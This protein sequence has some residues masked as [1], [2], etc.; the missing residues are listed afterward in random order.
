MGQLREGKRRME[1]R[2][3]APDLVVSDNYDACGNQC[4]GEPASNVAQEELFQ[5]KQVGRP[6]NC[7]DSEL[8]TYLQAL[9]AGFLPT[10]YSDTSQSAQSKSMNIASRSYQRGKKTVVFHGFPSLQMSRNLTA[11][12]GAGMSMSSAADSH[13]RTLAPPEKEQES[14]ASAPASGWK[15]RES[16]TRYDPSSRSWRTRQCS[17]LGDLTEF[18]E[19]W[20]RWG[21]MR[22]GECSEQ[23]TLAP[24]TSASGFG[25]WPTP[26]RTDADRGGRG[27]LIQAVRGNSN[28]HFKMWPTPHGFSKDGK[29]N[30][31]SGNELWRAVN[32][33]PFPTPLARDAHNRSG[34]AKRYLEQGRVNLQDRMAADGIRGSLNPTWVEWLMGWPLGWT[35][36]AASAM[37][38]FRVWQ[39]AHGGF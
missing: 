7:S 29:S 35:D 5:E 27:D 13:A 19:T 9:E 32:Q 20:P 8:S 18:S 17:L 38:R 4:V 33:R 10:F 24:P 30:G 11:P 39:Q 14:A 37:D 12:R 31:P 23:T 36:C 2:P 34:Q 22:D 1:H 28:S 16:F 3:L 26:R 25:S 15:W 21:S 6:V